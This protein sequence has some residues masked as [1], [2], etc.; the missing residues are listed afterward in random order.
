MIEVIYKEP[1]T[2]QEGMPF[3]VENIV[4]DGFFCDLRGHK[5][6]VLLR[7]IEGN[8]KRAGYR[9]VAVRIAKSLKSARTG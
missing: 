1:I 2:P 6:V 5:I 8:D 4:T 7:Y 9:R 3:S